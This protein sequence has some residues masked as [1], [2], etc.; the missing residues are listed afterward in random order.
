[1]N[2]KMLEIITDKIIQEYDANTDNLN[3]GIFI[4]ECEE[5]ISLIITTNHKPRKGKI[6]LKN[7][8]LTLQT[9]GLLEPWK[10]WPRNYTCDIGH[11]NIHNFISEI[12]LRLKR[13]F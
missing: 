9:Y 12:V 5:Y 3:D 10:K 1:M 7:N 4:H 6:T 13:G 11:E 8:L 2:N